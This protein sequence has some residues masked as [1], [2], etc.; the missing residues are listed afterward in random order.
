LAS[1]VAAE[2]QFMEAFVIDHRYLFEISRALHI[3][4]EFSFLVCAALVFARVAAGAQ[5]APA[6][7]EALRVQDQSGPRVVR[8]E[9]YAAR[10]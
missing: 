8:D 5:K 9:S 4:R 10:R 3:L 1:K 2:I 7:A 6:A